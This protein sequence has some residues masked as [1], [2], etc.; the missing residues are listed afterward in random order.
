MPIYDY[1]CPANGR[2]VEVLQNFSVTLKTWQDVCRE[3]DFLP[4]E[5]PLDARVERLITGGPILQTKSGTTTTSCCGGR[6]CA[7]NC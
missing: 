7:P 5:T 1:Y 4:G 2:T 3:G 6:G